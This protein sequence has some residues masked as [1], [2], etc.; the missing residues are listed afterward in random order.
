MPISIPDATMRSPGDSAWT[1]KAV[2]KGLS[3]RP[4]RSD[5]NIRNHQSDSHSH[6]HS[7]AVMP[8]A[9]IPVVLLTCACLLLA[10]CGPGG[11]PSGFQPAKTAAGDPSRACPDITGSYAPGSTAWLDDFMH[12]KRPHVAGALTAVIQKGHTHHT[13]AWQ[14]DRAAFLAHARDFALTH[15]AAYPEWRRLVLRQS[16][17]AKLMRDEEAYQEAVTRLGPSFGR[18]VLLAARQCEDH[19]ML[20]EHRTVNTPKSADGSGAAKAW[21]EELWLSRS[22]AGELLLRHVT[23]DLFHYT[24]WAASS[25]SLRTSAKVRYDKWPATN[26][27][28]T[29]LRAEELPPVAT[30]VS[31]ET[32]RFTEDRLA[33]LARRLKPLLP[34]GVVLESLTPGLTQGQPGADGQCGRVPL[35]LLFSGSFAEATTVRAV[36]QADSALSAVEPP[37]PAPTQRGKFVVRLMARVE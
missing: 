1:P 23:Y 28:A 10:A 3:D 24:F 26:G 16:L 37:R 33:A 31:R 36:L 11:P 22:V 5:N 20:I 4:L 27:D 15:P 6:S 9:V 2:P 12:E 17:P 35:G 30:P 34:A 32:C 13:L 8:N 18:T 7:P 19:W 14:G 25:S 21:D 29:P